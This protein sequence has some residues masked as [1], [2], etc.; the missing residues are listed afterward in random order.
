MAKLHALSRPVHPRKI[1]YE[2]CLYGTPHPRRRVA[3]AG[4][5]GATHDPIQDIEE[6]V[7]TECDEIERVEDGGHSSLSEEE[8]L[9]DNADGLEDFGEDPEDL[10]M[11]VVNLWRS[12][13]RCY[14]EEGVMP[15][16]GILDDEVP[17]RSHEYA[18]Q[19]TVHAKLPCLL[20][21]ACA[22][23]YARH[24]KDNVQ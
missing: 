18:T 22:C 15:K 13:T 24:Q 12:G 8:E 6:A 4:F 10:R 16:K 20:A 23:V 9:W 3:I 19:Q 11:L 5:F 14:L 17:E 1:D 21:F 2:C 7:C